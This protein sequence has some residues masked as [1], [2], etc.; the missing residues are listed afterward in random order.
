M[1]LSPYDND[2]YADIRTSVR[3]L[4]AEYPGDYWRKL[5]EVRAYPTEFVRALTEAGY[6]SVL[7]PEEYGGS[8]LSLSA[9]AAVLG[10]AKSEMGLSA[11]HEQGLRQNNRAENSHRPTRRREHKIQRFKSPGSA[12]ASCPFT[13]PSTTPSTSSAISHPAAR[14]A[15]C[16]WKLSGR[17]EPPLRPESE[18]GFPIFARP[19]SVR[20]VAQRSRLTDDATWPG[21][22]P[23]SKRPALAACHERPRAD[24]AGRCQPRTAPP[25]RHGDSFRLDHTARI[26]C[27]RRSRE[28]RR[29]RPSRGLELGQAQPKR[30]AGN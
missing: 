7:I 19:N 6:L 30:P 22:M 20:V 1:N 11:R 16:E 9:A 14:S 25:V 12:S 17:G 8:G 2:Q 3:K 18:L 28:T 4:C 29:V 24:R 5:D 15:L 27:E 26:R 21:R 10:A 13:P 23:L